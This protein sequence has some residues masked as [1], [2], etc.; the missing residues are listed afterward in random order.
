MKTESLTLLAAA[1]LAGSAAWAL[2]VARRALSEIEAIAKA[3]RVRLGSQPLLEQPNFRRDWGFHQSA[4]R[5]AG[6]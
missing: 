3:G 2:G 6:L 4:L 1:A 5:S